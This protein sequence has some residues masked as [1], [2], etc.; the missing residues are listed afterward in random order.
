M[1]VAVFGKSGTRGNGDQD[2][3]KTKKNSKNEN[4]IDILVLL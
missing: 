2:V 1:G 4:I 3:L